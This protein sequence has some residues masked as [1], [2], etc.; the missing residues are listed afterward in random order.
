MLKNFES[1]V[2][3]TENNFLQFCIYKASPLILT[4]DHIWPLV[5]QSSN[6]VKAG[7]ALEITTAVGIISTI[8]SPS[9]TIEGKELHPDQNGVMI[10]KFNVSKKP[11][12]YTLPVLFKY[13]QA[14]GTRASATKSITYN[15]E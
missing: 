15:V 1:R 2:R 10:Y 12:R 6:N 14:D 3:I 5:S 9:V 8:M 11:G 13:V 7:E 4:D